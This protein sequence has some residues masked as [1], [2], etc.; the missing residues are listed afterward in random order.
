M[1]KLICVLGAAFALFLSSAAFAQQ[2]ASSPGAGI[3]RLVISR[4]QVAYGGASFGSAGTYEVLAGTAYGEVDPQTPGNAGILNLNRAPL[5]SKGRVEYSVD[6][7][8]LKPV[9]LKK[10]NGRL[11]YDFVNRGRNTILRLD[12]SGDSF[13]P[14]DTGNAFLLNRG[15]TVAWSGWQ[16]D[17]AGNPALLSAHLPAAK[18]VGVSIVGSTQ[19]QLIGANLSGMSREEFTDVPAGPV[20]T[21]IL[22]YPALLDTTGT[23]L[24]VR[25][26]EADPRKTLPASSW[27]FIDERHVEITA[28][29]GFDRGALYELI[30]P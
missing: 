13:A 2:S 14:G 11:I 4:R 20:F 28:A 27:H 23:T 22:D 15:Y 29:P 3:T 10:G 5:N 12:E 17:L 7:M 19:T 26:R 21:Q 8:I 1:K 18:H 9:D 6:F 24:T 16:G 25:E 30:Y